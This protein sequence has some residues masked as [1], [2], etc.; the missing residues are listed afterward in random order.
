M[1]HGNT[2]T[3]KGTF[4]RFVQAIKDHGFVASP[5]PV[6]LT[7]ENHCSPKGQ[8]KIA[9]T[10]KTILKDA[11][12]TG[13][14]MTPA[15]LKYKVLIRDKVHSTSEEKEDDD[16][17]NWDRSLDSLVTIRNQKTKLS[18]LETTSTNGVQ[19][20]SSSW[21]ESKLRA[22]PN[23]EAIKTWCE[24]RLARIYPSGYRI[25][26]S[27]YDPCFAWSLGCQIVALNCQVTTPSKARPVWLSQGKFLA[28]SGAGYVLKTETVPRVVRVTVHS[29][30]GWRGGWGFEK[31][32]D[33]YAMVSVS[34]EIKYSFRPGHVK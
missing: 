6:I 8:A 29:A 20:T 12:V 16:D 1:T 3:S 31:R 24:T 4:Q 22:A 2:L 34:A 27:N 33:I 13:A 5:Y 7:L 19:I 26:S 32:P 11:L 10:L 15:A 14:D 23:P 21:S 9:E 25:D 28:N 17:T 30:R 18:D